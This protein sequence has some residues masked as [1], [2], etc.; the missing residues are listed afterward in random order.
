MREIWKKEWSEKLE[1]IYPFTKQIIMETLPDNTLNTRWIRLEET[2]LTNAT[3]ES[4]SNIGDVF[5]D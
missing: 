2:I 3:Q 4:D 5:T 1:N